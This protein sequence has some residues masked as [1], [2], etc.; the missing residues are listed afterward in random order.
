[1]KQ[2]YDAAK[3]QYERR[4]VCLRA[5]DEGAIQTYQ[6]VSTIDEIFGTHFASTLPTRKESVRTVSID[7]SPTAT[8]ADKS[9]AGANG[10]WF[11]VIDY[12]SGDIIQ[13]YYLTNLRK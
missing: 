10:G 13:S 4:A 3:S 7:L 2:L 12:A 6:P 8:G 9:H 5:I 1:L 11:L